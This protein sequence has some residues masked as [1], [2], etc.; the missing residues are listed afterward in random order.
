MVTSRTM[1]VVRGGD[2][3]S[4]EAGYRSRGSRTVVLLLPISWRLLLPSFVGKVVQ[5]SGPIGSIVSIRR[6]SHAL[7]FRQASESIHRSRRCTCETRISGSLKAL[8]RSAAPWTVEIRVKAC[9]RAG[10]APISRN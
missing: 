8:E 3:I 10:L 2:A 5:G 9:S 4:E 6:G 1:I 7:A